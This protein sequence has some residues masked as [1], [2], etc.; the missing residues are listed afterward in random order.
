MLKNRSKR[1]HIKKREKRISKWKMGNIALAIILFVAIGLAT[2]LVVGPMFDKP[3]VPTVQANS[4]LDFDP[5]SVSDIVMFNNIQYNAIKKN[6]GVENSKIG[7]MQ[8]V[9]K[10]ADGTDVY[11]MP[12]ENYFGEKLTVDIIY[13]LRDQKQGYYYFDV[14][15]KDGEVI[16]DAI[17]NSKSIGADGPISIIV[18]DNSQ[19]PPQ[20]FDVDQIKSLKIS[21]NHLSYVYDGTKTTAQKVSNLA[22]VQIIGKVATPKGDLDLYYHLGTTYIIDSSDGAAYE[23]LPSDTLLGFTG[24]SAGEE[25]LQL[26]KFTLKRASVNP[27]CWYTPECKPAIYLY[28]EKKTSVNVKI[29]PKG[30]LTYTNPKYPVSTGWQ[31]TANP[32]G[33][34]ETNN[35]LFGYLYYESNIRTSEI[36]VPTEGYVVAYDELSEFYSQLLPKLGLSA[37]ELFDFVEYWN[38]VLPKAPYYFVGIMERQNIDSIEQMSI[39]PQPNTT[40]RVRL[41]FEAL[42]TKKEVKEPDIKPVIRPVSGFTVVEWGGMVKSDPNSP[43]TCSQ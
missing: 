19:F 33:K 20:G 10:L 17:R 25:N 13:V 43:F 30:Y 21:I 16:P 24:Y 18:D 42:K 39:I 8:K 14:Y 38:G 22:G 11:T 4:C 12:D 23:Y 37:N 32:D 2:A 28:P 6:A 15:I 27:V 7:E 41:Y 5:P 29:M 35:E 1:H 31:V 34:I 40:V 26:R 9:G 36:K 3:T